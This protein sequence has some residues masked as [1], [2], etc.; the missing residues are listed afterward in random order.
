MAQI[1]QKYLDELPP[2]YRDI[3][4]SYPIFNP[5]RKLGSGVALQSL[6]AVLHDKEWTP[7][8]IRVACERMADGGVLEIKDDIWTFP[9][10]LGRELIE[11]LSEGERPE[12]KVP[13]FVPPT[14][15]AVV[16]S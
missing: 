5:Q 7:S 4:R 6:Y 16:G 9:T 10:D 15:N 2:I 12:E 11:R 14:A 3:L 13:P 1:T 8:Q